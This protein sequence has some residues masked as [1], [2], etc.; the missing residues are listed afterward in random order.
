MSTSPLVFDAF[1]LNN[2]Q[3]TR[4]LDVGCGHGKWGYLLKKYADPPSQKRYVAGIDAF[5]PHIQTLKSEGIYDDVRVGDA[6]DLP[7]EDQS[8]DT[9]IACEILEHLPAGQG[10]VLLKE[11]K[12]V[13]KEC[14][15]VSTPAFPCMRGGN[16]TLDG[17][18]PYEAHQHIYSYPE[19]KALGFTQL[20]GVGQLKLRPWKLSV[21]FASLGYYF[22]RLSRYLLGFWYADG[23]RRVL[24]AE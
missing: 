20:I 22:P 2:V 4:F 6:T 8:F 5:A 19:F 21:A 13:A 12:R 1:V 3:G 24:A 9:V 7:F 11:L 15:I 16:E 10:P 17:F 18:N 23:V 14:V